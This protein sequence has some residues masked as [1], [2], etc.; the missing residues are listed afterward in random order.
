MNAV[1]MQTK[2]WQVLQNDLNETSF[3]EDGADF[4]YLA[5][6]KHTPVGNYLYLPYGPVYRDKNGFKNA[7]IS[8]KNLAKEHNAI[9]IRIEPRDPKFPDYA[10]KNAKKSKDLNPKETW[11]LDLKGTDEELKQKLPSRLLRYHRNAAK[12]GITI[13]TSHNPDD[14]HYLLNLQKALASKKGINTFSEEYLKT[15]LKQPFSTLYLVKY[16]SPEEK[17]PKVVAAGLVFDDLTTRYNLQGAQSEEARKLHATGVLTIQLILDAKAAGKEEFDFW[18]I[19]PEGA[20]ATHPWKG[21]TDF[22]KTFAGKERDFA[23]TYDIIENPSKYKLYQLTRKINRL[24][25]KI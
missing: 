6:L 20:P 11:V 12:N 7:L 22:K 5:I 3:Y 15:E 18:G 13:E 25:R 14:I 21:F 9:F 8:L 16:Q 17:Q 10:P 23:G 2:E 19:A 4:Q 1:L 24:R